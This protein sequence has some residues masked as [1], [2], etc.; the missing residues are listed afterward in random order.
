MRRAAK[1]KDNEI[2]IDADRCTALT[3]NLSTEIQM[4]LAP[5]I[6]NE[7]LPVRFEGLLL[8]LLH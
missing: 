4:N 3:R 2:Y 7:S 8:R 6:Q 1:I 5:K